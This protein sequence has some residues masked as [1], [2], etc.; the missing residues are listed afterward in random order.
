M[1][2]LKMIKSPGELK[3][4]RTE[5]LPQVCKE[6]RERI[7]DVI[8]REGG[9]LGASLG[10]TEITVALHYV[11][12]APKDQIVWDT[13]H[14]AYG[15]KILTGRCDKFETIRQYRGLSGFLSRKES[16]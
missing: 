11:L 8:S 9:H 12:N 1:S 5:L 16:E 15:H 6:I 13:G 7:L 3:A 14:Q 2:L 4:I 10:A